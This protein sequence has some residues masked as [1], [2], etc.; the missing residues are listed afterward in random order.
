MRVLFLSRKFPPRVGGMEQHSFHLLHNLSAEVVAFVLRKSQIHLVWW[1]PWIF[2]RSLV[3]ARKVDVV[4]IADG[5]LAPLAWLL[6]LVWRRPAVVTVHGLDLTYR[7]FLYQWV[8]VSA[9]RRLDAVIAVS[10]STRAELLKRGFSAGK[11][12]VIPNGVDVQRLKVSREQTESVADIIFEQSGRRVILDSKRILLSVGRLVRRKGVAWFIEYVFAKLPDEYVYCVAGVGPERAPIEVLIRRY[13][14]ENRVF[15]LGRVSDNQ[16]G[17]LFAGAGLFIMPN[18]VVAGDAEGFG[19]VALEAAACGL[20]VLAANIDGLPA[21]VH[22]GKNGWLLP[23][24]DVGLWQAAVLQRIHSVPHLRASV[25]AYT[26][27][28]F[29]WKHRA[30]EY[31]NIF[32]KVGK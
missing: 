23:S 15:L 2:L 14:L 1:L 32:K 21:A 25:A 5:L 6:R 26:K 16:L 18:I 11:I 12:F 10:D 28:V 17:N 20:P 3:V 27:E 31:E 7:N 30:Q 8:N 19:I 24:G 13:G 29:S 22:D 9:L 4:Y